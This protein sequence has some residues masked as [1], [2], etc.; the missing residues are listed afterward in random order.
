MDY[1]FK[2]FAGDRPGIGSAP[3]GANVVDLAMQRQHIADCLRL[4]IAHFHSFQGAWL[5]RSVA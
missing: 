1:P 3:F 4:T 5:S 2:A